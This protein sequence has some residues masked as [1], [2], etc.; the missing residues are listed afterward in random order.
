MGARPRV[1]A[2]QHVA[3]EP[4]ALVAEILEAAGAAL[5]VVQV[6]RGDAVPRSVAPLDGLV[7]MGG[8]MG[9][10]DAPRLA[11]LRDEM[12]LLESALAAKIPVLGICLGSQLLAASL[13][14]R[15]AAAPEKE[16]GWYPVSLEPAAAADP[17][18]AGVPDPFPA[19]HW[20]GD[21]F[22]APRGSVPLA[23]SERTRCQAF[24][25]GRAWGLLFHCEIG[26]TQLEGMVRS[27]DEELDSAG[28]SG[29]ALLAGARRQGAGAARAGRI[30][31]GNWA[32]L[33]AGG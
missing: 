17:L 12:A 6:H 20:H 9:V 4:P 8:P 1:L 31:Y 13:G 5:R 32:R 24:R 21:A 22:D 23:R 11:H 25:H 29:D 3:E 16:I 19:L 30:L 2:V 10:A 18:F 15:V 33:V 28:V 27:F 7:V 14:A 26:R